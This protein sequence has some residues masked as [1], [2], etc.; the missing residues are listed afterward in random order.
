MRLTKLPARQGLKEQ[1]FRDVMIFLFP[2]Q[3]F[4]GRIPDHYK[5]RNTD[6]LCGFNFGKREADAQNEFHRYA[7]AESRDLRDRSGS[8]VVAKDSSTLSLHS[9]SGART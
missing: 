2:R 1:S 6:E 4:R 8:G 3:R 9:F 7:R 5:L